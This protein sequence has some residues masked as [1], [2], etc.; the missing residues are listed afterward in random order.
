MS[1]FIGT[2]DPKAA[3][4]WSDKM[5]VEAIRES[6]VFRFMGKDKEGGVKVEADSGAMVVV[7]EDLERGG[8]PGGDS[9]TTHL[10]GQLSGDGRTSGEGKEGYG[11]DVNIWHDTVSIDQLMHL[12]DVELVMNGYRLA[13]SVQKPQQQLLKD[14]HT[15]R[16]DLIAFNH[17]CGY[18]LETRSKYNGFNTITAPSAGRHFAVGEDPASHPPS[19]TSLGATDILRLDHLP[20]MYEK[21]ITANIRPI[22]TPAGD[23]FVMF[24]SDGQATQLRTDQNWKDVQLYTA[25]GGKI[26]DNPMFGRSLGEY[27]NIILHQVPYLRRGVNAGSEVANTR[28]AVCCGAQALQIAYGNANGNRKDGRGAGGGMKERMR[29]TE[30]EFEHGDRVEMG[31]SCVMGIKKTVYKDTDDDGNDIGTGIDFGAIVLTTHDA[32]GGSTFQPA[33]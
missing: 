25:A 23:K 18:T 2:D 9:V 12:T 30:R 17:L 4:V 26:A 29:F 27:S 5:Y 16:H 1:T 20:V 11:E 13:P 21:M 31:A 19:E 10:F 3:K 24:I 14:W 22:K 8:R 28:R 7:C 15:R 32:A 33:S 6:V